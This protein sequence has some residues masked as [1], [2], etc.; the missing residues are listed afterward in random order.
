MRKMLRHTNSSSTELR[1]P[2]ADPDPEKDNQ[3][4][5]IN[6]D[7]RM[8]RESNQESLV[9]EGVYLQVPSP[10]LTEEDS[11]ALRRGMESFIDKG[12]LFEGLEPRRGV[13]KKR[14]R[15]SAREKLISS[16]S[17]LMHIAREMADPHGLGAM[18]KQVPCGQRCAQRFLKCVEFLESLNE[19]PRTGCLARFTS[20]TAF[21]IVVVCVI[22]ANT[23]V[24]IYEADVLIQNQSTET[25]TWLSITEIVFSAFYVLE[26]VL[27]L[28]ATCLRD[29]DVFY[30]FWYFLFKFTVS[31]Q[32][33]TM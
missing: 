25:F 26:F 28:W 5:Q 2:G 15:L 19:P 20:S 17:P 24:T 8:S 1:S 11:M 3:I 6:Q 31:L 23:A 10:V 7:Y 13:S 27:K 30:C 18:V 33:D 16:N 4:D 9:P 32:G 14:R 22:L 12:P 21:A 29:S